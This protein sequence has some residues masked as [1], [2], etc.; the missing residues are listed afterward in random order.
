MLA[1]LCIITSIIGIILLILVMNKIETPSS[2]IGSISKTDL[3]KAVRIK[4]II[5]KAMNNNKV[6][7]LEVE[8]KSGK[9]DVVLFKPEK[10]SIK[11]GSLVEIE[12]KVSIYEDN[13]QIY[14][15]TVKLLN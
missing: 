1:K 4:G 3:N 15:E 6:A 7:T 12:G 5:K 13:L 9:I 2:N 8:D 11:K 14:A 10:L